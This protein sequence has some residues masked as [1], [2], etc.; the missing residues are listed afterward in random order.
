MTGKRS[1][2]AK[3]GSAQSNRLRSQIWQAY[4]HHLQGKPTEAALL[5]TICYFVTLL[6]VRIF[7]T[8]TH[9]AAGT[10][11]IVIG[12][13]H[14]HHVVFGIVAIL[15]SGVMSLDSVLRLPRA[16]LFG[17]GAALVLDEFALVVFLKDVYWLPQG[18]LSWVA[19]LV[20]L[21]ALVVNT[22]RSGPFLRDVAKILRQ[23]ISSAG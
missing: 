10:G 7:T 3:D 11:D 6:L 20:G 1:S 4:R 8:L 12:A 17:I 2:R 18:L 21:L 16:A 14:I 23:R 13:T 22:W 19:I 5:A 15:V 9:P